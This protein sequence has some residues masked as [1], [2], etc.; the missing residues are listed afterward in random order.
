MARVILLAEKIWTVLLDN[1][2]LIEGGHTR[3]VDICLLHIVYGKFS[4]PLEEVRL[5]C[6]ERCATVGM[7]GTAELWHQ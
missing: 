6:T 7:D 4:V 2:Q 1:K 5:G 3:L